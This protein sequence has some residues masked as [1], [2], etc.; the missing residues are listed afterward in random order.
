MTQ[1]IKVVDAIMGAGKTSFAIQMMNERKDVN[2]LYIT[3]LLNECDRIV[4][5]CPKRKFVQPERSM[6]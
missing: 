5:A 6:Q 1:N 3:P 4:K 2:W